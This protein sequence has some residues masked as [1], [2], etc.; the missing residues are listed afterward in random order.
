MSPSKPPSSRTMVSRLLPRTPDRSDRYQRVLMSTTD[1]LPGEPV[2]QLCF[3]SPV[4]FL[5]QG[6]PGSPAAVRGIIAVDPG[7]TGNGGS[8]SARCYSRDRSPVRRDNVRHGSS[9]APV[10][11]PRA[12]IAPERCTGPRAYHGCWKC[13]GSPV[14]LRQPGSIS[15]P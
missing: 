1:Q 12:V 5:S 3:G 10:R 6:S 8:R 14:Y 15:A 13:F 2:R 11:M 7:P 4:Q 9:G